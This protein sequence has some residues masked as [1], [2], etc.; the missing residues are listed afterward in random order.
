M[1]GLVEYSLPTIQ[2]SA[3]CVFISHV[4]CP[5]SFSPVTYA[6][7]GGVQLANNPKFGNMCVTKEEFEESGHSICQ[8]KFNV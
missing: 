3:I 2:N 6:W 1:P 7:S 4:L 5:V 8:E